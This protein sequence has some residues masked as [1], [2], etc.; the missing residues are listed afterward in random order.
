MTTVCITEHCTRELRQWE[1][2]AAM[3]ICSPCLGQ[4]RSW[5]QQIPAALVVLRD[6]SMQRERTDDS[7][8]RGGTR[9]APLP[10]RLDTL[11]L[12]GPAAT[13]DVHDPH[14]DQIGQRPIVGVLGDWVRLVCAERRLNGPAHWTEIELASWLQP[15]L[16]WAA[17]QPWADEMHRELRDMTWHIRGIIRTAIRTEALNRPCPRCEDLLLQRTDHDLYIRCTGCGNAFTQQ[18]LN[19]DAARRAAA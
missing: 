18:E 13:A 19:D 8:G 5:L 7:G 2:T 16:G 10:G 17:T 14:G 11:N 15:H 6:G 4:M 1:D 12:I 3:V 9:T